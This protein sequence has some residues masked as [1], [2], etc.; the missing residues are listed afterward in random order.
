MFSIIAISKKKNNPNDRNVQSNAD[1]RAEGK[2]DVKRNDTG[3]HS[4]NV[5]RDEVK[6]IT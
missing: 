1:A 6:K 2:P 5:K 4:T 3:H